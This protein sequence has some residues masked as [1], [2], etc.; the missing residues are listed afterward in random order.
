MK[1]SNVNITDDNFDE[2]YEK[3]TD[4]IGDLNSDEWEIY[5][6]LP[7]GFTG[8]KSKCGKFTEWVKSGGTRFDHTHQNQALCSGEV[9]FEFGN[10]FISLHFNE[11]Y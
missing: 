4:L 1:Y 2:E 6:T 5:D 10:K 3:L 11:V 7:K 9:A 8:H